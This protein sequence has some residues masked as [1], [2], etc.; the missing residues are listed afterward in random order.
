MISHINKL[1]NNKPFYEY[2]ES[3]AIFITETRK[4]QE[5]SRKMVDLISNEIS[6]EKKMVGY[7]ISMQK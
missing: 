3:G 6:S 7:A 4:V 5:Y 2:T 1:R